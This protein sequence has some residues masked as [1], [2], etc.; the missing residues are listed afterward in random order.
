MWANCDRLGSWVYEDN[1]LDSK[2]FSS[3]AWV[4]FTRV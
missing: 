4:K 3:H 1:W 2:Y